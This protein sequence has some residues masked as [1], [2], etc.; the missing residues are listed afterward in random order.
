MVG[1]MPGASQGRSSQAVSF[2][3]CALDRGGFVNKMQKSATGPRLTG[4]TLP[5]DF[6]TGVEKIPLAALGF[7]TL[8]MST[9]FVSILDKDHRGP[10]LESPL[11]AKT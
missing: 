1:D 9:D 6:R 3:I 4:S 8:V 7:I 5:E 10:S 11:W 2:F